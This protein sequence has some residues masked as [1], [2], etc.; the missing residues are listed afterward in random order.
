MEAF[1]TFGIIKGRKP[2]LRQVHVYGVGGM[3]GN[4]GRSSIWK[5]KQAKI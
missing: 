2:I 4:A 3:V 1:E 5:S